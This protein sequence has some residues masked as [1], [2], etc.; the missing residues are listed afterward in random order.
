MSKPHIV[1]IP[2]AW[3]S[4]AAFDAVSAQL[5]THGYTIHARQLPAV[6]ST[7]P[8]PDLSDDIAVV[9]SLVDEAIGTGND[10][11]VI[12]HSWGGIIA[13]SALEGYGKKEREARGAKGGVVRVAYIAAFILDEGVC[14]LDAIPGIPEWWDVKVGKRCKTRLQLRFHLNIFLRTR[15][16]F[17]SLHRTHF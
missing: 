8:S 9:Q 12:P 13:G 16:P 2:G 10:V 4:P 11:I 17:N 14:L 7:T 3:H 5:Q 15:L 1:L 6:G